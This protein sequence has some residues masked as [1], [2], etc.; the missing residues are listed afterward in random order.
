M[1]RSVEEAFTN[2][3]HSPISEQSTYNQS[4][5]LQRTQE[6]INQVVG[7]MQENV[8]KVLERDEKISK[9]KDTAGKLQ[10]FY[11]TIL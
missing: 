9:I 6:D 4:K 1:C 5:K 3:D 10:K 8:D 2:F 7:I 11:C